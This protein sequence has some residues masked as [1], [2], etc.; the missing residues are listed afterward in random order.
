MQTVR[1]RETSKVLKVS[2][3]VEN[4]ELVIKHGNIEHT[5]AFSKLDKARLS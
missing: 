1:V 2:E 3:N 5:K 4:I